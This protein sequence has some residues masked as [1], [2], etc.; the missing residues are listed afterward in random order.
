MKRVEVEC[1]AGY[2]AD[3]RPVRVRLGEETLEWPKWKTAGTHRERRFFV[4]AWRTETAMCCGTWK[5]RIPG[6]SRDSA[7]ARINGNAMSALKRLRT[8]H[9]DA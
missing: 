6:A 5:R 8:G 9:N 2:R 1:Y 4:C 3:E 7:A